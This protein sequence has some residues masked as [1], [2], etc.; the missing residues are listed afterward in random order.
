MSA[1]WPSGRRAAAE[2]VRLYVPEAAGDEKDLRTRICAARDRA[3]GKAGWASTGDG[4][5]LYDLAASIADGW[6]RRR[7]LGEGDLEEVLRAFSYIAI[8]AEA[9]ERLGPPDE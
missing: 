6:W 5:R 2:L 4:A 3:R 8:A 7:G 9:L 1:A